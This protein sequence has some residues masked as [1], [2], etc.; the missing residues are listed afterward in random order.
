MALA[1]AAVALANRGRRVLVVDFDLEAPGLDTFGVMQPQTHVPG[2]IDYVGEYLDSGQAPSVE[3][4]ISET[5]GAR[6]C[7][8]SLW[9]MPSGRAENYVSSFNE[10]DWGRLYADHD[11]FLLFEDLKAQW[12][13]TL[14]PDYVLIDSRTGHTD[15][16]GIC[17]RQL[18]DAVV[19]FFFPNEQNLRGLTK[20]VQDIRSEALEPRNRSIELHF[21]MSNVPDLDDEDRIL[22]EKKAAF[23]RQLEF[24][25]DPLVVHRYDSLS[26]LNQ[27]VFVKDRP[28]SRLAK[29]YLRIVSEIALRNTADR[30]GALDYIR[31]LGRSWTDVEV[32]D[33]ILT[34]EDRLADIQDQHSTDGEVL[35]RLAE[36]YD[37]NAEPNLVRDLVQKSISSGYEGPDAYLKRALIRANRGNPSGA[38]DDAKRVLDSHHAS[39]PMVSKAIPLIDSFTPELIAESNA[40]TSLSN[41]TR[42]WLASKL[43]RSRDELE[44]ANRILVTIVD[45]QEQL[46]G[47]RKPYAR[48]SHERYYF[49]LSL[50]Y[51]GTGRF[52]HAMDMLLPSGKEI[53]ELAIVDAFNYGMA[54]WGHTGFVKPEVFLRVIELDQAKN[55]DDEDEPANYHQCISI[56][57]WAIGDKKLALQSVDRA[58]H[59]IKDN[60]RYGF[61]EDGIKEFSCWRYYEVDNDEFVADMNEISTLIEGDDSRKPHFITRE[62]SVVAS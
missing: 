49:Q 8:G 58:R 33:T 31:R 23:Q 59:A 1:N 60:T 51:I 46:T 26:L 6:E 48:H 3:R 18:P 20:V 24:G 5:S 7:D 55:S 30:D 36:Y 17:T 13:K 25:R 15:T 43:N 45:S 4:F 12:C 42:L 62:R 32:D 34:T 52:T 54:V 57:Y 11:G 22:D 53:D 37:R 35:F 41:E 21:V 19:I 27:V 50:V 2:I 61:R 39:P 38:S 16:G 10:I 9:I 40:V 44:A 14:E 29:E 47:Q 28:R 56:A